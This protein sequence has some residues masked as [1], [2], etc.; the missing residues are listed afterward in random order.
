MGRQLESICAVRLCQREHVHR[1]SVSLLLKRRRLTPTRNRNTISTRRALS[2]NNRVYSSRTT[3]RFRPT[4]KLT[5]SLLVT[6]NQPLPLTYEQQQPQSYQSNRS[7]SNVHAVSSAGLEK[8]QVFAAVRLNGV[9]FQRVLIDSGASLSMVSSATLAALPS[10]P[11][12][13]PFVRPPPNI[14]GIGGA[15]VRALGYV[16]VSIDI[17]GVE[18]KHP[19][20][21]VDELAF[22][23]L[24]GTDILRP[25]EAVFKVSTPDRVCLTI[26]RCSVCD[27]ERTPSRPTQ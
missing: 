14:V 23:F 4:R 19:L 22:P 3:R 16:D 12:V 26:D 21:V 13:E 25:H 24:I 9:L 27:E 7:Q 2:F 11:S 5:P 17:S 20:T 10:R 8:P 6:N 18:V 15:S 1:P